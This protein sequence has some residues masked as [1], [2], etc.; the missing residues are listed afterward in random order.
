MYAKTCE[1]WSEPDLSISQASLG[2]QDPRNLR[3]T[4]VR[5]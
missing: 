2:P 4:V 1:A 3:Q 5:I